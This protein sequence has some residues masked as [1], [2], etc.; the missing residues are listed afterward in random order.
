MKHTAHISLLI[1]LSLALTAC[2][3]ESVVTS[4]RE[5][6]KVEFM[7]ATYLAATKVSGG[8][9]PT[10]QS[11]GC[12]AFY[13]PDG[14][15]DSWGT[16]MDNQ[17]VSFI[18]GSWLP[19]NGS[20]AA[21][22]YYWPRRNKVSFLS[23]APYSATPWVTS[24]TSRSITAVNKTPAPDDDWL[25]A[26]LAADYNGYAG[27]DVTDDN[28]PESGFTGVPTFFHHALARVSFNI[29]LSQTTSGASGTVVNADNEY[30]GALTPGE[31]ELDTAASMTINEESDSKIIQ[32]VITVEHKTDSIAMSQTTVTTT[33][34]HPTSW[35]VKVTGLSFEDAV[36]NGTIEFTP[37]PSPAHSF[38]TSERVALVGDWQLADGEDYSSVSLVNAL[39]NNAL[40]DSF[41]TLLAER[42]VIPQ[43]LDNI[44]LHLT[45]TSQLFDADL[46]I[47]TT[48]KSWKRAKYYTRTHV[49]KTD[50]LNG[51][52][53]MDEW[54]ETCVTIDPQNKNEAST[55]VNPGVTHPIVTFTKNIPLMNQGGLT[56]WQ[57]NKRIKYN[58]IIEPT[59]KRIT[60]DPAQVSDWGT[61]NSGS[62][63]IE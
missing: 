52:E 46:S 11:F 57:K 55:T 13:S 4:L 1:L 40:T 37:A 26:D 36:N 38:G 53:L 54:E 33:I 50:I 58:I 47:T 23:Y 9:F 28:E 19:D 15:T 49:V 45:Y 10:D 42:S 34:D 59:G 25:Y 61:Y 56:E 44:K 17:K 62:I 18:G 31:W 43:P 24:A 14:T 8:V 32:T 22:D 12:F 63:T 3:K 35:E 27:S 6:G 30:E 51:K 2:V 39:G 7:P 48:V 41:Q 29:K 21:L 60:W 5:P 20:G 16:Y